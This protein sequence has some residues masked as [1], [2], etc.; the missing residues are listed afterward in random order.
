VK[1]GRPHLRDGWIRFVATKTRKVRAAPHEIPVIDALQAAL[2]AGPMGEL[3]FLAT[4]YRRPFTAAGFGA[5]FRARC[6]EAGLPQC[7]AHGLR[8]AGATIAAENGA[9]DR[10]L[11]AVFGWTSEGQ[12]TAYTRTADRKRLAAEA[13][14]LLKKLT[15]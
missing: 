12:A 3:T 9:T 15:P 4:E 13:M 6:D 10:Q 2:D 5:W 7:T 1:I 14:P 11:M 8:K